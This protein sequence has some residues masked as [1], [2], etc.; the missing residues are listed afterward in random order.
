MRPPWHIH[1]IVASTISNSTDT[2]LSRHNGDAALRDIFTSCANLILNDIW[3]WYWYWYLILSDIFTSNLILNDC[4]NAGR[5]VP[6]QWQCCADFISFFYD[7]HRIVHSRGLLQPGLLNLLPKSWLWSTHFKMEIYLQTNGN[8]QEKLWQ[9]TAKSKK[10]YFRNQVS[11]GRF[12]N[13]GAT[14][15]NQMA[16]KTGRLESGSPTLHKRVWEPD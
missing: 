1:R 12:A 2:W 13:H 11:E 15:E 8:A 7:K 9:Q 6:A 10:L 16:S 14:S 3:Y 5:L 4:A